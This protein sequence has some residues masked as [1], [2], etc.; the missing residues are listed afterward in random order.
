MFKETRQS[1]ASAVSGIPHLPERLNPPVVVVTAGDPYIVQETFVDKA[2]NL[3]ITVVAAKAMSAVATDEL[4]DLL[5]T[6]IDALP[7][8][9]SVTYVAPPFLLEWSGATYL[10]CKI[11][12]NSVVD[13]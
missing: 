3:S 13:A 6:T 9:T 10:A 1:V 8:G 2:M 7:E 11:E 4:D 12:T 5:E